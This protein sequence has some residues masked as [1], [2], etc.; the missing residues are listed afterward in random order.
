M[1]SSAEMIELPEDAP[2]GEYVIERRGIWRI[3][4]R[5]S[6]G[7]PPD[8]ALEPATGWTLADETALA[9]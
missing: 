4:W 8:G 2:T 6:E 3:L 7:E 5:L 9:A 1:Q